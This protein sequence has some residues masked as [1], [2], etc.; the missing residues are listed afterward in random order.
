LYIKLEELPTRGRLRPAYCRVQPWK[1]F[2][3]LERKLTQ[4]DTLKLVVSKPAKCLSNPRPLP[5]R[6]GLRR[7]LPGKGRGFDKGS[8]T[9][10][11]GYF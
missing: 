8:I 9:V 10:P 7:G 11:K 4:S 6:K 3:L 2:S 5:K 1:A